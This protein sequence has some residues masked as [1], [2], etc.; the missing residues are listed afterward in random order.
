[1]TDPTALDLLVKMVEQHIEEDRLKFDGLNGKLDKIDTNVTSLL[2]TRAFVRG[3]SKMGVAVASLIS[4][5]VGSIITM[6]VAWLLR[7]H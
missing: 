2:D 4:G 7:S 1:M 5:G 6:A 3:V